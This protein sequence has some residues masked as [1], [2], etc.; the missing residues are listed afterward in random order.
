[1]QRLIQVVQ[2]KVCLTYTHCFGWILEII[3]MI[4]H[5]SMS[6]KYF[7][8]RLLLSVS[9][10][11]VFVR[12]TLAEPLI[13]AGYTFP[14]GDQEFVDRAVHISG[15]SVGPLDIILGA[16]ISTRIAQNNGDG[17]IS[18]IQIQFIDN[19]VLNGSG[20]DMVAFEIS[21][22]AAGEAFSFSV[23]YRGEYKIPIEYLP[24]PTGVQSPS[25]HW[26]HA[27]E[28]DLSS[29]GIPEGHT[30]SLGKIFIEDWGQWGG[31][32]ISAIGSL[33]SIMVNGGLVAYWD[34][35]EGEG[36]TCF[37]QSGLGNNGMIYGADWICG[38]AGSALV[39]DGIDDYV[40]VGE[41]G[42]FGSQISTSTI[43][44]WVKTSNTSSRS[45]IIHIIDDPDGRPSCSD[46]VYSI[47]PNR[48]IDSCISYPE[49][50]GTTL[51]FIRDNTCRVFAGYI[52]TN[53]YDNQWHHIV[54]R[55]VDASSN[56]MQ[57][58]VDGT[59]QTLHIGCAQS[60]SSFYDWTD[61]VSIGASNNR[62][63]NEAY[64]NGVID[65]V[66]IYNR[67]LSETEIQYLYA[68][69][70]VYLNMDVKP[71]SCP[72]PLNTNTKGKGKLPVVILG[73]DSFDVSEIDV[74]SI[75]IDGVVFPAVTPKIEDVG[76]PFDGEECECHSAGADG[77][78]DLVIHFS[79]REIILTLGLNTLESGTVVPITVE[80]SLLDCRRFTATDCVT[81]VPRN[82]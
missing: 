33:H 42:N 24:T 47:E 62:G 80:G 72:N 63:T 9:L 8:F 64:F 4:N 68:E 48:R 3:K 73:T 46:V 76:T 27:A 56:N 65:E 51:F 60:P 30:I 13:I 45:S 50:A 16:D 29:F 61:T 5:T 10:L 31:A 41:L 53:I 77:F 6:L 59:P 15:P 54:W 43:S 57:V 35:N 7:T 34:Y 52:N 70:D 69:F 19:L 66:R 67:A 44:A 23:N 74:N 20:T 79:R 37:D 75:A 40:H 1:M 25:G 14:G 21:G 38:V 78:N 22:P 36:A 2:I 71:G 11:G 81:L 49:S 18:E 58:Y 12:V 55:I 26:L 32:D 28:I 17:E 82:D 39:F